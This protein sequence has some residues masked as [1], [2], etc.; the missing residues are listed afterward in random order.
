MLKQKLNNKTVI[1]EFQL[2]GNI[3]FVDRIF[4]YISKNIVNE[5]YEGEDYQEVQLET[6]ANL[7]AVLN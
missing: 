1:I 2:C 7:T 4:Y 5:L 3:N 6:K